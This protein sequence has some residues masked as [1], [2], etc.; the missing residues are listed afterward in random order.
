MFNQIDE[1]IEAIRQGEMIIVLDDESRENEG[2]LLMAA[3]LVTAE[4]YGDVW[5]WINLYAHRREFSS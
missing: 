2:D 4:F 5:T 3:D 1:A